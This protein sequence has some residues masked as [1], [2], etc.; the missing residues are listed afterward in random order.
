MKKLLLF[1]LLSSMALFTVAQ[2]KLPLNLLLHGQGGAVAY[3]RF[4]GFTGG[5][6]G[7]GLQMCLCTKSK[8]RPQMDVAANLFSIN[9]ILFVYENGDEGGPKQF[10]ATVF[11]GIIYEPL[12]RF[13]LALSAGP[14]FHD[15]GTDLGIKPYAAFYLGKKKIIKAHTSL[16]HIFSVNLY[17]KKNLGI[18][19]AG[20]AI[21]L[22]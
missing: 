20:L 22:F 2:K 18:I 10:V 11:G 21:K 12:N 4:K 7:A 13:E 8:L 1:S 17:K 3:D 15:Y 9:K 6:F 14:A 5:S 19:N 16:T